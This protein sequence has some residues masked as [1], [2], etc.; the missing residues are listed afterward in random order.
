MTGAASGIGRATALRLGNEGARVIGCDIVEPTLAET[1]AAL[2][3]A[4]HA[5]DLVTADITNQEDV[6]RVVDAAGSRIDILANVAGI[7]DYVLPSTRS[8]TPH[9]NA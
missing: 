8:T 5:A 2:E 1:K 6:E 7:M 3:Q 9:G 4:A